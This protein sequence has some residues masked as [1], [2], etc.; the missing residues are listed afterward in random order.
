MVT[1]AHDVH[2]DLPLLGEPAPL[3]MNVFKGLGIQTVYRG[4]AGNHDAF[5]VDK[6]RSGCGRAW[7]WMVG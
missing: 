4:K 1:D 3:V 7:R 6:P 5:D 2:A